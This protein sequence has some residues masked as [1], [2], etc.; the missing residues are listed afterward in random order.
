[1]YEQGVGR[2][3]SGVSESS[4]TTHPQHTQ[5]SHRRSEGRAK[6]RSSLG[7][8]T[9]EKNMSDINRRSVDINRTAESG[10][11]T[12][13][14]VTPQPQHKQP[15]FSLSVDEEGLGAKTGEDMQWDMKTEINT[16]K[17]AH[18]Q[19]H[20]NTDTG[21]SLATTHTSTPHT[22]THTH[23]HSHKPH[24]RAGEDVGDIAETIM[25]DSGGDTS[26]NEGQQRGLS[27]SSL[28]MGN[29]A[30]SA[31]PLPHRGP[32]SRVFSHR[33][34]TS[35]TNSSPNKPHRRSSPTTISNADG[36]RVL[37]ILGSSHS[38]ENADSPVTVG[39]PTI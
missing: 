26:G 5:E 15:E 33:F 13:G 7:S 11:R 28:G 1:M 2:Y 17:N 20:P 3:K 23:T 10:A 25:E 16:H 9:G 36:E 14:G 34:T 24:L 29:R 22:H 21:A 37:S 39:N 6:R 35:S 4:G 8:E 27:T 31:S 38:A 30:T 18:V 19:A 32:A 12:K